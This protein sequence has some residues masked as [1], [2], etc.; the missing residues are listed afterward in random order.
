[1]LT[2][3]RTSDFYQFPHLLSGTPLAAV[4]HSMPT[5]AYSDIIKLWL[6]GSAYG[7][8]EAFPLMVTMASPKNST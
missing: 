2:L 5:Q 3:L 7:E 4:S 6:L 8:R 1:M